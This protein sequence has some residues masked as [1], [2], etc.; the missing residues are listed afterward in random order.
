MTSNI[1][2]RD[3]CRQLKLSRR[4][5][6]SVG[7]ASGLG[8]SLPTVL[9]L[10]KASAAAASRSS[11]GS[12]KSVIFIFLHGGH[13]QHETWDPKLNASTE[14]R[15][16]FG[17][18][19]TS[20]PGL[21]I[22]ELLPRSAK[23]ADRLAIIRSM[24]HKNPNHV[25]ACLPAM[26]GHKHDASVRSRGDFP[27]SSSD[28]PHFGAV[29]DH[30]HPE[31]QTLP[32]WVQLGPKMTRSNGTDLH[33]QSPGFLGRQHTPLV[34]DQDLRD[35]K[36][37]LEILAPRIAVDRLQDRRQLLAEVESQRRSIDQVAAG[38]S[39]SFYE[40]AYQL[41]A[42]GISGKAF[43]LSAEPPASRDRYTHSQIGRCCLLARRLV[44]AGVPFVNVHWCKTPQGSWDTHS[45]NFRKMKNSL[46]PELDQCFTT[47]VEDLEERGLLDQV[48]VI[49]MAEFGRTPKIN[50]NAGRDHWPSVY[51]LAMA[52][53]GLRRGVVY[54]SSDRQG[55]FP[56]SNPHDPADMAATIYHLLGISPDTVLYDQ[57]KRPHRLVVGRPIEALLN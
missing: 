2:C 16:E 36:T 51:S 14:V 34:V 39:D 35:A 11:F 3:F 31:A 27:P 44:E 41:L 8:L 18:I 10:Q 6:L 53:A 21:R 19:A 52:G 15:G 38:V 29:Y 25:Q 56:M 30:L 1:G 4:A 48:L 50:K 7:C 54:G 26:T 45:D 57:Q 12:A 20:V 47:L 23:I 43:D 9:Q 33:G 17:D 46:A 5:L 40:R 49:P 13:P 42:S 37:R 24:S 28:F 55:A 32:N 22:S